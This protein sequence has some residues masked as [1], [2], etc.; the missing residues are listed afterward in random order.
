MVK[1]PIPP[2]ERPPIPTRISAD[3]PKRAGR[4]ALNV[5]RGIHRPSYRRP[6]DP[7]DA[8]RGIIG[9]GHAWRPRNHD[10]EAERQASR[11][12]DE[13]TQIGETW[14]NAQTKPESAGE[15][16][17]KYDFPAT[18]T[19]RKTGDDGKDLI[20]LS[21]VEGDPEDPQNWSRRRKW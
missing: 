9:G 2:L 18:Y 3:L 20:L 15:E 4:E 10:K 17:P 19:T 11:S 13:E 7:E 5:N 21:F 6:Q 16:D 14:D 12:D 8:E 1:V